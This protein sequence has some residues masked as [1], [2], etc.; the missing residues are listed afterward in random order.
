VIGA[1][2]DAIILAA[3]GGII[4]VASRHVEELFGHM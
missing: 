4:A 1:L 2:D 3:H